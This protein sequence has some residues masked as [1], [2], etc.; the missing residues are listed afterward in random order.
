[1]ATISVDTNAISGYAGRLKTQCSQL[2]NII[3]SVATRR[4]SLDMQIAAA[5]MATDAQL[6]TNNNK[7]FEIIEGLKIANWV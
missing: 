4:A 1:M 2:D 7:H 6:V 3:S 5:A